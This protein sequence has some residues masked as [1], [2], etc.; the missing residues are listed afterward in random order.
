M[1]FNFIGAGNF[2]GATLIPSFKSENVRLNNIAS[3]SGLKAAHL[4][5]R[6]GF[7]KSTSDLD[8][9]FSDKKVGNLVIATRHDSHCPLVLKALRKNMNVFVEKPLCLNLGELQKIKITFENMTKAPLLMVG[10]NRRFAPH[11][12]KIKSMIISKNQRHLP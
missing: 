10:F 4:A 6:F 7:S 9:I 5:K 8:S 2:A 11:I 3:M 12:E 1:I